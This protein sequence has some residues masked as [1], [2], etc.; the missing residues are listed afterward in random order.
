MVAAAPLGAAASS[1]AGS[2]RFTPATD[3]SGAA[4]LSTAAAAGGCGV[5]AA[6]SADADAAAFAAADAFPAAD[7]RARA[8]DFRP[9]DDLVPNVSPPRRRAAAGFSGAGAGAALAAAALPSSVHSS[10]SQLCSGASHELRAASSFIS[11]NHASPSAPPSFGGPLSSRH[12]SQRSH[13]THVDPSSSS[14]SSFTA[15]AA[16]RESR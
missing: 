3:G 12:F 5:S 7:A 9:L 16:A 8:P 11:Q 2:G 13:C 15:G 14:S 1:S 10:S 4:P 6:R